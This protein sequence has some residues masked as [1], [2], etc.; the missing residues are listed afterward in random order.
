[1][2]DNTLGILEDHVAGPPRENRVRAF[3]RAV[4][5]HQ[6]TPCERFEFSTHSEARTRSPLTAQCTSTTSA[7][8]AAV[9][10]RHVR[11]GLAQESLEGRPVLALHVEPE[12]IRQTH[13]RGGGCADVPIEKSAR[14]WVALVAQR[15]LLDEIKP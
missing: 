1:M 11:H 14:G 6:R 13:M 5:E 12:V 8:L 10:P 2:L 7:K 9:I 3:E 15:E 4:L